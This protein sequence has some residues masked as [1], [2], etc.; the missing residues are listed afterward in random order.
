MSKYKQKAKDNFKNKQY[1]EAMDN[2]SVALKEIPLD[3]DSRIGVLLADLASENELEA[4]TLFDFYESAKEK[5]LKNVG[6]IIENLLQD[7]SISFE[8]ITDEINL[9]ENAFLNAQEGI[10]YQDFKNLI[11]DRDSFKIA[12][13]DLLF[14]TKIIIHKKEDF[15]EFVSMLMKNGYTNAALNYLESAISLYPYENFFQDTLNQLE[16]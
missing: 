10:E 8:V 5:S 3:L 11:E 16:G 9:Y 15:K 6:D 2:Y 4:I 7:S 14:S 1:K 13:E 12:I